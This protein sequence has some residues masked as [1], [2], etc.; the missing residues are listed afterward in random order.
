M[1]TIITVTELTVTVRHLPGGGRLER[2]DSGGVPELPGGLERHT[3]HPAVRR[4]MRGH[5]I[6]FER[7]FAD[8]ISYSSSTWP[9]P[10]IEE[11]S[12]ERRKNRFGVSNDAW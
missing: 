7:C 4:V 1:L 10:C 11:E 9:N 6:Q 3:D 5:Y 2:S 12:V 8:L